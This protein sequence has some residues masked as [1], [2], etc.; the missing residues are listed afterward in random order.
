MEEKEKMQKV[1]IEQHSASGL[2]WIWTWLF[3]IGF[4]HLGFLES[5]SR[6][7]AL[8]L[9]PRGAFQHLALITAFGF[10]TGCNFHSPAF[11]RD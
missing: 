8:A 9:L 1:R 4:L 5:G 6:D 10:K 7:S 3:T 2:V 11:W